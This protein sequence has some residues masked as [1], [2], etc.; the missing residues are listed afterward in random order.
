MD[1][2]LVTFVIMGLLLYLLPS[3]AL[4]PKAVAPFL[5][6][7]ILAIKIHQYPV[8]LLDGLLVY[9]GKIVFSS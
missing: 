2:A 9:L 4:K 1:I 5:H 7:N 3:I 8:F 6:L